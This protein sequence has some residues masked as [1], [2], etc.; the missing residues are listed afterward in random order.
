MSDSFSV[1][2]RLKAFTYATSGAWVFIK[3]Q[4]SA[5]I[6]VF[7]AVSVV[8]AGFKLNVTKTD[9]I[10]LVIAMTMV[11]VAECMNTAIETLCDQVSIEFKPLIKKSKD[12]AAGAVLLAAIGATIIGV[13][14]FLPY[15]NV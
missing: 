8:C 4:H 5:W 10:F 6:H 13:I 15:V 3:T 2:K 7:A 12:I 9:W 14:V 1:Q 11:W